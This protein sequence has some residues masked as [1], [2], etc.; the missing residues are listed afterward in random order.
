MASL[1]LNKIKI[2]T[3]SEIINFHP[4]I[5]KLE[6]NHYFREIF[7][8]NFYEKLSL[9]LVKFYKLTAPEDDSSLFLLTSCS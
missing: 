5:M 4:F 9:I 3:K 6:L 8:S 7:Y 2:S 1:I